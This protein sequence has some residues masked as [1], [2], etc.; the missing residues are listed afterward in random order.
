MPTF[1]RMSIL[2]TRKLSRQRVNGQFGASSATGKVIKRPP[3]QRRFVVMNFEDAVK[4]IVPK[5]GV[6]GSVPIPEVVRNINNF[7]LGAQSVNPKATTK[8]MWVNEWFNPPKETEAATALING[9]A[10]ILI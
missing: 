4:P 2:S 9:G 3:G 7:T 10:D 5:L 8:V 6:V 1:S